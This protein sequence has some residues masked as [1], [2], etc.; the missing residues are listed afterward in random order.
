MK[1][2]ALKV[3]APIL[4]IIVASIIV[5]SIFYIMQKPEVNISED[6]SDHI[7]VKPVYVINDAYFVEMVFRIS[8]LNIDDVH[9]IGEFEK[10]NS[11]LIDNPSIQ[12]DPEFGDFKIMEDDNIEFNV[13]FNINPVLY[14]DDVKFYE[15]TLHL[16]FSN[17]GGFNSDG[18]DVLLYGDWEFDFPLAPS[19]GE[20][21]F[22]PNAEL[23]GMDYKVVS[24]DVTPISIYI[25]L[26]SQANPDG[27][28]NVYSVK[29]SDGREIQIVD[30][31]F[32][33]DGT[34]RGHAYILGKFQYSIDLD[35]L[36]T[37]NFTQEYK[38]D[39]AVY[40]YS[41]RTASLG[42]INEPK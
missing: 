13:N 18:G 29:L 30:G 9:M 15:Q 35:I 1:N 21:H 27:Y 22:E 8:G 6:L 39:G 41:S 37:I 32:G 10:I 2:P 28:P 25:K 40:G 7:D 42:L 17:L 11:R 3:F 34:I 26:E 5:V 33:A 23:E 4:S 36:E 19:L 14:K 12:L 38:D 20:L 31:G 24:I 16:E